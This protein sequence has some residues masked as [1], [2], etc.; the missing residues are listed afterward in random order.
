MLQ[1]VLGALLNMAL[2]LLAG[3]VALSV[4]T[5]GQRL[6]SRLFSGV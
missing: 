6:K 1:P 5:L 3:G 2:G 4:V